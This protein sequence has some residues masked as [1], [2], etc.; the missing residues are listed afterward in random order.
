MGLVVGALLLGWMAVRLWP[1]LR[2]WWAARRGAGEVESPEAARDPFVDPFGPRSPLRGRPASELVI[3]VY[4]A[5]QAY[6]ALLG[7]PRREGVTAHDFLVEL[8]ASAGSWRDSIERLTDLYEAA[9]YTPSSVDESCLDELRAI[10]ERLMQA[11][12]EARG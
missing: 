11:V 3:H 8:P 4:R 9:E 1:R 10:W 7:R 12:R 6:M 2:A 5:F